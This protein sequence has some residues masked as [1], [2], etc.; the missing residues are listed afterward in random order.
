MLPRLFIG[1]IPSIRLL[2]FPGR[3]ASLGRVNQLRNASTSK[4]KR[5]SP[6]PQHFQ[7]KENLEQDNDL[8]SSEIKTDDDLVASFLRFIDL[9]K[10]EPQRDQTELIHDRFQRRDLQ[11]PSRAQIAEN[12]VHSLFER[13]LFTQAVA[14]YHH[15]LEDNLLPSPSTDAIFLAM[16]LA[17]STAPGKEQLDALTTILAY[18]SFTEAH[19]MEFLDHLVTLNIPLDT[20][21]HLVRV[22]ISV[23]GE[24][25]RPSRSLVVKLVDIQT[26]AGEIVAAAETITQ[27]DSEEGASDVA[28]PY[29]R[30]IKSAPEGDQEAV[31]WIM[32]VMREKDVPISIIVFNALLARQKHA[33]DVRKAFAFYSVL[34]HLAQTSPLKPNAVT[35]KHLFRILGYQYK[36][37]HK[38]NHSRR[39][40]PTGTVIPPRQLF[41]EMMSMWFSTSSHPPASD[42]ALERQSQ[43]EMDQ[44]LLTIAF[45]AFLYLDDYGAALAVLRLIPQMGL[46]INERT[47]FITLRFL[48]R[49]IYYDVYW[50]RQLFT[51]PFLAF[52]L[53]GPF[54]HL[55][56]DGD[57]EEVY[58]WI[59]ERLLKHNS[60]RAEG[61]DI[62]RG[63]TEAERGRIPTVDAI[64]RH[65]QR[66]PGGK[67]DEYPILKM[68]RAVLQMRPAAEGLPWGMVWR[69]KTVRNAWREMIPKNIELWTWPVPK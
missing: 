26:Q 49:R 51:Q 19:F 34:F 12:V 1:R 58:R 5:V 48:A 53:M 31:D 33:R 42:S 52:E 18:R 13:R 62:T 25:Y 61:E 16:S 10:D 39:H 37:N 47:Y 57:P 2:D 3:V 24:G 9:V 17:T 41:S 67:I 54:D 59:M 68:L 15:M 7:A 43:I 28:E 30:I 64:L 65:N 27:Y 55:K 60:E 50:A 23:K 36:S 46:K 6:T 40:E 29:A 63:V 20:I 35:Y 38:P 32:G 11:I 8:V 44:A 4:R 14:V 45:R 66:L 69:K 21:E 22:F 56:M